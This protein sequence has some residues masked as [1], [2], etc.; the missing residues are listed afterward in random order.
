MYDYDDTA[1][2]TPP[3]FRRSEQL[4]RFV[5]ADEIAPI[6]SFVRAFTVG[7]RSGTRTLIVTGIICA[8]A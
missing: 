4:A 3:S 1:E 8:R 5:C 6:Y 2:R 7:T